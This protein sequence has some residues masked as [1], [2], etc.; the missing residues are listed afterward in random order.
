MLD[1]QLVLRARAQ[2]RRALPPR[3]VEPPGES[4]D[5]RIARAEAIE[6]RLA[7]V[8]S[9]VAVSDAIAFAHSRGI[10][11][12]DLKP[13]NILIGAFGETLV[14]DWGLAKR[15]HRA[16]DVTGAGTGL[17]EAPLETRLGRIQ[18]TPAY[19]APEQASGGPT[20]ERTDVYAL[21]ALLFYVLAR[22][23]PTDSLETAGVPA[24][25]RAIARKALARAPGDRYPS[26]KAFADELRRYLAG[27]IVR[28]RVYSRSELVRRWSR[29]HRAE[30]AVAAHVHLDRRRLRRA[31]PLARR[32]WRR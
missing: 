3:A 12:R 14:A 6:A 1:A 19:M 7:L 8:P 27:N 30:L 4:L 32:R 15:L 21:G 9:L 5:R 26:A 13:H 20:D 24:D 28:A 17:P 18:G 10:V 25:L 11:H 2:C 22:V 31:P 23:P 29:R 16:D